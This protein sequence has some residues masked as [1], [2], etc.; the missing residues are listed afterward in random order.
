MLHKKTFLLRL[1]LL[2]AMLLCCISL[3]TVM[4]AVKQSI[5]LCLEQLIPSL[6]IFLILANLYPMGHTAKNKHKRRLPIGFWG[7]LP[8]ILLG[9]YPIGAVCIRRFCQGG[10]LTRKQARCL[11]PI[12]F[13]C[14]PGFLVGYI[15][16]GQYK[17]TKIG[18]LLLLSQSIVLMIGILIYMLTTRQTDLFSAKE[19]PALPDFSAAT[20]SAVKSMASICATVIFF[21]V[22]QTLLTPFFAILPPMAGQLIGG[23]MEVTSGCAGLTF[24]KGDNRILWMAFLCGFGG[25]CVHLQVYGILKE[26]A[27]PY[28]IFA[29]IRIL[30]AACSVSIY[31]LLTLLFPIAR[32]DVSCLA[33][34]DA[35]VMQSSTPSPFVF[36]LLLVCSL[37]AIASFFT[38]NEPF[39][40][41]PHGI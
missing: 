38:E 13:C 41:K 30:S 26:S 10:L 29:L 20:L 19:I 24:P 3:P 33:V 36:A 17:N 5:L 35:Y 23:L 6:M 16:I 8:L 37:L 7:I 2:A 34:N 11:S 28:P 1:L 4:E 21:S 32:A 40:E 18:I 25:I 22:L 31:S 9:G 12:L 15:G 14:G 39:A 27:P